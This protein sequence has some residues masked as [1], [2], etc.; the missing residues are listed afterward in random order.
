MPQELTAAR[1]ARLAALSVSAA[2]RSTAAEVA[3]L[4]LEAASAELGASGGGVGLRDPGTGLIHLIVD[5]GYPDTARAA[6]PSPARA[7]FPLADAFAHAEP[8]WLE[9]RA[10]LEAAYPVLAEIEPSIAAGCW[11]PMGAATPVDAVVGLVFDTDHVFDAGQRGFLQALAGVG[12]LAISALAPASGVDGVPAA[13]GDGGTSSPTTSEEEW[14]RLA[15]DAPASIVARLEPDATMASVVTG[16]AAFTGQDAQAA[17][18]QG[19]LDA[20][21]PLERDSTEQLIRSRR[22]APGPVSATLR[23]WHAP[24]QQ[25]RHVR[26]DFVPVVGEDDRVD[27]LVASFA[28]VD[29]RLT[30]ESQLAGLA[31]LLDSFLTGSPVG[32][33]LVDARLRFQLV[34]ETMAAANGMPADQHLGRRPSEVSSDL[35]ELIEPLLQRVLDTQTPILGLELSGGPDQAR[36][37]DWLV[38]YFPV[39][40]P[41]GSLRGV[42]ATMV[43]ITDRNRAQAQIR[44]LEAR[45]AQDRFRSALDIIRDSVA[46]DSAIRDD[47]GRIVDFRIEYLNPVVHDLGGRTRD[48]LTGATMLELWP[49]LAGSELFESYVRAVETGEAFIGHE[50]A[51][52]MTVDGEE[53]LG[54]YDLQALRF[55][56]GLLICSRD[57]THEREASRRLR[58]ATIEL[59]VEHRIVERLQQALLPRTLPEAAGFQI[60]ACYNP[61][62]ERADLGGD[63]YDAFRLPDGRIGLSIGDVTGHGLDAAAL[64][65]QCRLALRA[66]AYD[67][68][69]STPAADPSQVLSRLD[70]LLAESP[71]NELATAIYAIYDP[72]SGQLRWARAGH[73]LPLVCGPVTRGS[74]RRVREVEPTGGPPLGTR[75]IDD[76]PSCEMALDPDAFVLLYTDGLV[77]R[78]GHLIDDGVDEVKARLEADDWD[79]L[80]PL[81]DA[82][83][84]SVRPGLTREDDVC[85]LALRRKPLGDPAPATPR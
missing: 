47:T 22:S 33:A 28:D 44:E 14:H 8:I 81:C 39:R 46:I 83:T 56:D 70:Q 72:T 48:E 84:E 69:A 35:G 42:G 4:V 34:N 82:L 73:P 26:A 3:D 63:W 67:G 9:D 19:W 40:R 13:E 27:E 37:R 65:A 51:Q 12:A 74:P 18:G 17:A 52:T 58:E 85:I 79:A 45:Q 78:R 21:H 10:A 68:S 30:A 53:R 2:T 77:E 15:A 20:V 76:Y 1:L 16:W 62:D 75:L 38:N 57:V 50:V 64:M 80:G 11:L 41:D 6:Y 66:Y 54:F 61:V 60:A 24:S 7:A 5:H 59:A 55:G 31:R 23:L 25:W 43:D 32:F 71:T 36:P 49:E 29:A